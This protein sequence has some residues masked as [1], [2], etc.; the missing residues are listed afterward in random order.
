M[1]LWIKF[2]SFLPENL[3]AN[4]Y[5]FWISTIIKFSTTIRTLIKTRT[6]IS[7]SELK[8]IRRLEW[9]LSYFRF[10]FYFFILRNSW[11]Y[12]RS[13]LS[14][15]TSW[16]LKLRFFMLNWNTSL[17]STSR[18]FQRFESTIPLFCWFIINFFF[19]VSFLII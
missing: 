5:M 6:I 10:I 16:L 3:I 18:I 15:S 19:L 11:F 2:L 4:L 12:F 14:L 1:S 7:L 9:F 17:W 8:C 13:F